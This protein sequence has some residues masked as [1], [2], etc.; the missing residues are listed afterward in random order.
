MTSNAGHMSTH[1]RRVRRINER[2][3][4]PLASKLSRG[5]VNWREAVCRDLHKYECAVGEF[6]TPGLSVNTAEKREI[7]VSLKFPS[8]VHGFILLR[9]STTLLVYTRLD[10]LL[11]EKYVRMISN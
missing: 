9:H 3:K 10:Q 4:E 11:K 8:K 1:T 2:T 7:D 5:L 6:Y